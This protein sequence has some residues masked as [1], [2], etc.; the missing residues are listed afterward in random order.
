MKIKYKLDTNPNGAS[1]LSKINDIPVITNIEK[2]DD[3]IT[4]KSSY[5]R[6]IK[7]NELAKQYP[8]IFRTLVFYG[9]IKDYKLINNLKLSSGLDKDNT[10]KYTMLS[11]TP[12]L[13][14]TW[15]SLQKKL[16][17]P[18]TSK[19]FHNTLYQLISACNILKKNDYK[20][21]NIN[22]KNIMYKLSNN[23]FKWY[24]TDYSNIQHK[25]FLYNNTDHKYSSDIISLLWA[26]S[27]NNVYNNFMIKY[28][29][30]FP[31]YDLFIRRICESPEYKNIKK[32]LPKTN[33]KNIINDCT[34]LIAMI[35]NYNTYMEALGIDHIVYKKYYSE[36]YYPDTFLYI[37]K[38]CIDKNYDTILKHI[39]PLA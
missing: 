20:H 9:V 32:Y 21:N 31:N 5:I 27:N 25:L 8:D 1:Y 13:D 4:T 30:R 26:L 38:H 33:N 15:E 19:Q 24:L 23:Q 7:F 10:N 39:K 16:K 14:G 22:S 12:V 35:T 2:Y 28:K 3:D 37:I 18:L 36:Q 29:V 17:K 11:Y 34:G 6:Q